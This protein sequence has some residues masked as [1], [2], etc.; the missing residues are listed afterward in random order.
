MLKVTRRVDA[1]GA[2]RPESDDPGGDAG[3]DVTGGGLGGASV[4]WQVVVFCLFF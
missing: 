2:G 4:G 3:G 1:D